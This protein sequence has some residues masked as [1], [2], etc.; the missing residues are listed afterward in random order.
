MSYWYPQACVKLRILPEDFKLVSDASLQ[1]PYEI[2]VVAR[3]ITINVN[4]HKTSDSF[5]LD[6]EYKT[7]PFDPRTVRYCGVVIYIQDMG[8]LMN[9]DGSMNTIQPSPS[10]AVFAGFVDEDTVSFDETHRTVHFEGRDFTS[11]L[12]DQKYKENVPITM[13]QPLDVAILSFLNTFKA[14][15]ELKL[16]NK[17]GAALPTL[18]EF[19]PDFSSPLSGAKN[20]GR[21]ESY[22][23]IIQDMVSRA[24]LICYMSLDDLVLT[25]PR[26]LYN[27]DAD[28]KF[29]YG[30]NVKSF[31]FKR[32]LGR[33][34]NFNIRVRSRVGKTVLQAN[35]PEEATPEWAASYGIERAPA[36]VPVLKP[37]GSLDTTQTHVAPYISFPVSNIGN[38]DQLIRIGQSVYEDYSRQQLEGNLETKD[39]LAHSATVPQIDLTQLEIGQPI[40]LEI[41]SEDLDQISRFKD[42]ET[43]TQFLIKR[44]YPRNVASAFATSM[45]K[46][47]QRFYTKAYVLSLN[48]DNGF[49]LKIDFIN[50]IEL[51]NRSLA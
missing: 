2:T 20:P 37:D 14:T 40:A 33:L 9:P 39:M 32:K 17:T 48:Q 6:L 22:W 24:G 31:S 23:E 18:A 19:Y 47:S 12:I 5:S 4:D 42:V 38:K 45:G 46:F 16:I 8:S 34:K 49:S 3:N 15:Q 36:Q 13:N 21:H 50:I 35:I 29:I 28:A 11:L 26:N 7:F 44:N 25:T 43:R 51:K 30:K 1:T 27:P 10:N 41:D